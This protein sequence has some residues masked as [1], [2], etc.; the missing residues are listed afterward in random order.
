[1]LKL[2]LPHSGRTAGTLIRARHA[3]RHSQ[4]PNA[5]I[6]SSSSTNFSPQMRA[7]I[8]F[9]LLLRKTSLSRGG[10]IGGRGAPLIVTRLRRDDVA[11]ELENRERGINVPKSLALTSPTNVPKPRSTSADRL[12]AASRILAARL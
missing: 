8:V 2:I 5:H 11:G 12:A 10:R 7:S 3:E 1:M 9:S 4:S 6:L